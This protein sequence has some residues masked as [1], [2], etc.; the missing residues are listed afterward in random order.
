MF[1]DDHNA[2]YKLATSDCERA[3]NTAE[4]SKCAQRPATEVAEEMRKLILRPDILSLKHDSSIFR[5]SSNPVCCF[6]MMEQVR[7]CA[8]WPMENW[9][10][11]SM[12]HIQGWMTV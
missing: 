1:Q 5:E 3:L 8:V 7:L 6:S 10:G 4:L 11:S 12:N 9:L 2:V